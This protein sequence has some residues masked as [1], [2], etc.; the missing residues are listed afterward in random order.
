MAYLQNNRPFQSKTFIPQ[1]LQ[2]RLG[3]SMHCSQETWL[4]TRK[5]NFLVASPQKQLAICVPV[6]DTDNSENG[7]CLNCAHQMD[8]LLCWSCVLLFS[9]TKKQ[10]SVRSNNWW[11]TKAR[12]WQ[13]VQSEPGE[14]RVTS[15]TFVQ[16]WGP[17]SDKQKR[18]RNM[19]VQK[20]T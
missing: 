4:N 20:E 12:D 1:L 17:L 10:L 9:F 5:T 13:S 11:G 15:R 19:K 2:F 18:C 16:R 3:P 6:P 14:F 7:H 8:S